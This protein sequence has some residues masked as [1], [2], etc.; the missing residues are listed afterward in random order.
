MACS[1][2][3]QLRG[4]WT[5]IT[6]TLWE[7]CLEIQF[8]KMSLFTFLVS[9]RA[10]EALVLFSL[11]IMIVYAKIFKILSHMI[12]PR[13]ALR[14]SFLF[15]IFVSS[16]SY[17]QH[18]IIIENNS[19]CIGGLQNYFKWTDKHVNFRLPYIALEF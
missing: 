10:G 4:V 16:P 5:Q 11:G 17:P 7:M 13:N 8:A 6:T 18:I 9:L 15:L 14:Q 1:P 2:L 19:M 3:L 12:N